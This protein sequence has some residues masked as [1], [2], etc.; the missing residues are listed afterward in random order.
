MPLSLIV[1]TLSVAS[2]ILAC[3]PAVRVTTAPDV[4]T[5]V[6]RSSTGRQLGTLTFEDRGT[7]VRISGTLEGLPPGV[8]GIHAHQAGRCD[9]PDFA[10]AGAHHNPTGRKHG[11]ENPEGPHAG[12][13]PNILVDANVATVVD[14]MLLR[15]SPDVSALAGLLDADG[16]AIVIHATADDQRTDPSGNSGAR[17][18][19]GVIVRG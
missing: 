13:L 5:A 18:A 10:T 11:L 15:A 12:D 17:I 1:V 6:V 4:A 16:A 9:A 7:G 19:C 3:R 8:H 2:I 14:L